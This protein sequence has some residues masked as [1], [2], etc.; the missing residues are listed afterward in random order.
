MVLIFIHF[1]QSYLP[2]TTDSIK[3][4]K[5]EFYTMISF[6]TE[7]TN[8]ISCIDR[9]FCY[10]WTYRFASNISDRKEDEENCGTKASQG[11]QICCKGK[12]RQLRYT[13]LVTIKMLCFL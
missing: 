5:T 8:K 7:N 11:T 3:Y 6:L 10:N 9:R 1:L 2:T 4:F 13:N 12:Y